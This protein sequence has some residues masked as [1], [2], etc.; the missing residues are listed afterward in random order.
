VL[1]CTLAPTPAY[2][3]HLKG[4]LERANRTV[5]Q[6]LLAGLPF[7]TEGP[8]T[9]DGRLYGPDAPPMTLEQFVEE[10]DRWVRA[11]NTL[12]AHSALGGQ[13]PLQRW[14][15]DATPL[16]LLPDADLRW[17]LLADEERTIVKDGIHFHGLIFVAPELN[18]RVGERVAIR[19]TPHDDRRIEIFEGERWVATALPQDALSPEDRD[20]VLD[21][22]RADAQEQG[23]RQR[24]ASRQARVRLA[25][26]TQPGT[27]E[28]TT[29]IPG[30]RDRSAPERPDDFALRRQARTGL[31]DLTAV[32]ADEAPGTARPG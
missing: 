28:T 6:E 20:R 3:P 31:L 32:V 21:Q 22:R 24:R 19:Y 15:T 12:R 23:R 13:T 25:A 5:T 10:F 16:Q 29:V 8:R 2:S 26:M 18:A 14:S 7:Y 30:E 11:Y 4:K 1:G 17:L 27:V 9:I